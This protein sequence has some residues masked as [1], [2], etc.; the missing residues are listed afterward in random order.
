[1]RSSSSSDL[2]WVE[3][4]FLI[5]FLHVPNGSFPLL[6]V[7]RSRTAPLGLLLPVSVQFYKIR[8]F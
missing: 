5:S 8:R 1:M 3:L 7:V 4:N 6:A 2:R